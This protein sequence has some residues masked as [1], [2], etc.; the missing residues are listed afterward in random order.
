LKGQVFEYKKPRAGYFIEKLK[1]LEFEF[2]G[3]YLANCK[4]YGRKIAQ[5]N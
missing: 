3:D 4:G 1:Q 2:R 5:M